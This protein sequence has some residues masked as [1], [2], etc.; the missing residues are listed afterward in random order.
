MGMHGTR[1]D[2]TH[3]HDADE[4]AA[5]DRS[6]YKKIHGSHDALRRMTHSH[7]CKTGDVLSVFPYCGAIAVDKICASRSQSR[8]KAACS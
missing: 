3:E 2:R 8:P 6:G 1:D 5:E 7:A 4:E